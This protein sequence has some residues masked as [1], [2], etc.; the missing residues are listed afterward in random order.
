MNDYR[1]CKIVNNGR[2]QVTWV[3]EK[4]AVVGKVLKLKDDYGDWENGWVVL[5]VN[6]S[7]PGDYV[8]K[9]KNV[10]KKQRKASDLPQ[11]TFKK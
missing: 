9:T 1:Q 3:P 8:L 11:G 4:F 6:A 2:S 10:W 5:E 7:Q